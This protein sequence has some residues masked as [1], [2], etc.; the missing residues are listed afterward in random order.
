[1]EKQKFRFLVKKHILLC[2]LL[3]IIGIGYLL[4]HDR[5][6]IVVGGNQSDK[7]IV[8][9]SS[10]KISHKIVGTGR[11]IDSIT[12]YVKNNK[13]SEDSRLK[14]SLLEGTNEFLDDNCI[15]EVVLDREQLG[16]S[17]LEIQFESVELEF[18]RD[19]F[20]VL[21]YEDAKGEGYIELFQTDNR[22][23][24]PAY[25]NSIYNG[26]SLCYSLLL[27]NNRALFPLRVLFVYLGL[28]SAY[29]IAYNKRFMVSVGMVSLILGIAMTS[30]SFMGILK[31]SVYIV[32]VSALAGWIYSIL[33]TVF[34]K[35]QTTKEEN[36]QFAW[37]VGTFICVLLIC[38]LGNI[39]KNALN[40]DVVH[41]W[42]FEVKSLFTYDL[43]PFHAESNVRLY[44]Y[45]PLYSLYQYLFMNFNGF[46]SEDVLYIAKY[47]YITTIVMSCCC[48]RRMKTRL[49]EVFLAIS[50]IALMEI[51]FGD[52]V[53]ESA[54][55][56]EFLG[57]ALGLALIA[58]Y[59]HYVHKENNKIE[60]FLAMCTLGLTKESGL[61][62][63]G[64]IILGA[65][66][67]VMLY[68]KR[69]ER[70][71]IICSLIRLGIYVLIYSGILWYGYMYIIKSHVLSVSAMGVLFTT[72]V[73]VNI[74]LILVRKQLAGRLSA[75][76][77]KYIFIGLITGILVVGIIALIML[78]NIGFYRVF[79]DI[80]GM[81][82]GNLW[83]IGY[84]FE[85]IFIH[86]M[87]LIFYS[88]FE[89]NVVSL[90]FVMIFS[91]IMFV[92]YALFQKQNKV[93]MKILM[94]CVSFVSF[95]YILFLHLVFTFTMANET[96]TMPSEARYLGTLVFAVMLLFIHIVNS[97]QDGSGLSMQ[98]YVIG[99]AAIVLLTNGAGI[100]RKC[101]EEKD[102]IY[103]RE[104]Y[105]KDDAMVVRNHIQPG[106]KVLYI[107]K[108]AYG[109]FLIYSYIIDPGKVTWSLLADKDYQE[110]G[111]WLENNIFNYDYVYVRTVPNEYW[112]QVG[113]ILGISSEY[114]GENSLF[115]VNEKGISQV[116]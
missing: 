44:R 11:Y 84:Q 102:K 35:K 20:I 73:L 72:A 21:T 70:K 42:A 83:D 85:M 116:Y 61:I 47:V 111:E 58:M 105:L 101:I 82:K 68:G 6:H 103:E 114:V 8:A 95:F 22:F 107:S 92:I 97:T 86:I 33:S 60:L 108:D 45:P 52:Y 74:V 36:T 31:Y 57:A 91:I 41:H 112:K 2:I 69:E 94:F 23:I 25:S 24:A 46:W 110:E 93:K 3:A 113:S 15:Q 90:P 43:L 10:T 63:A 34:Q 55:V 16:G 109:E 78:G 62:L 79:G 30:F 56:D 88:Y 98:G 76:H 13:L 7:S 66:I 71:S 59:K 77:K 100:F 28:A 32:E 39:G 87:K 9:D 27:K 80:T 40:G 4:F 53:I 19:Y 5:G 48:S 38:F 26:E 17:H 51:I 99:I 89:N 1:M 37:D 64:I 106:N 104:E 96:M 50:S 81:N 54:Y 14:V 12:Y 49:E 18:E 75:K 65:I 67:A 29:S 115:K